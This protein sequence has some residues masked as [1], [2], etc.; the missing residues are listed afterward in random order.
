MLKNVLFAAFFIFSIAFLLLMG[1]PFAGSALLKA[2]PA[3]SL[4][5]VALALV[6][7]RA[8]KLLVLALLFSSGGDIALEL[9]RGNYFVLGLSL[10][11]VAHL[12]YIATFAHTLDPLHARPWALVVLSVYVILLTVLLFPHLGD[13]RIPVL[14]YIAVITTMGILATFQ[15]NPLVLAGAFLFIL[16][17]SLIAVDKFLVTVPY[18]RYAI[19]IT[20]YS[21]QGLLT[22]GLLQQITGPVAGVSERLISR[23]T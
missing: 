22:Y 4:M 16:S 18:A 23:L 12:F 20:Y 1:Q 7:G 19:M 8:G 15:P 9:D 3:W 13:L 10:F 5:L 14:L 2:A 11:L 17:D 6:P 21:A